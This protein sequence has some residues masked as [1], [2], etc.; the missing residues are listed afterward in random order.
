MTWSERR[1]WSFFSAMALSIMACV[2]RRGCPRSFRRRRSK[3]S[4]PCSRYCFH[5]RQSVAREGLRRVPSGKSCSLSA[6]S[7]RKG[8]ASSGRNH[9]GE[10]RTEQRTPENGPLLVAFLPAGHDQ[11]RFVVLAGD[12]R[13]LTS[14]PASNRC[15]TGE[16]RLAEQPLKDLRP[17]P[18]PPRPAAAS[19]AAPRSGTCTATR[20]ST[21]GA[22]HCRRSVRGSTAAPHARS[23]GNASPSHDSQRHTVLCASTAAWRAKSSS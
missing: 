23:S 12:E 20:P 4:N 14:T 22:G 21:R 10:E 17:A 6:S 18:T 3:P 8:P 5:F 9:S 19:A 16:N 7:R 2:A 13:E 1:G 11:L 15:E